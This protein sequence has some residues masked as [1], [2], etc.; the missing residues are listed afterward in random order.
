MKNILITGGFGFI[1]FN[2][3]R[4]LLKN[5]N[6]IN[7]YVIDNL[8]SNPLPVSYIINNQW[9]ND[10]RVN[11]FT[12]NIQ[13]AITNNKIPHCDEVYH[14]ASIVGPV[15]VIGHSGYIAREIVDDSYK[16][17]EF[18]QK[19][20]S[21]LLYISTSEVYGGGIDGYCE[22]N[23]SCIIPSGTSA[24]LEYSL[25]KLTVEVA[26]ANLCKKGSLNA[27]S[28]RLFNVAGPGQSACGGFVLPRFIGQAML[29]QPLT[30][31]GEGKQVRAF[32]HV[33]DIV[34]GLFCLMQKGGSGDV[35]NIGADI[36]KVTI[37][38]LANKVINSC[39][40]KAK[41]QFC[42][43]K[44]LFGKHFV[45]ASDKFPSREK[46]SELGWQPEYSLADIIKDTIAFMS[47]LEKDLFLK[48]INT[49]SILD[50]VH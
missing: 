14:L 34:S 10:S 5:N 15:G 19:Y 35:F 3:V 48:L 49:P 4:E 16:I 37:I 9:N 43:P 28:A 11:Y 38:D 50:K 2:L 32:T 18:C 47:G 20:S 6:D 45:E 40:S 21:R 42:D 25:A 39:N 44:T 29:N 36:N 13:N 1:G 22:E 8:S 12:D 33:L 46:I 24:R 23:M 30:V 17:I 27:V 31:Y 26:V 41:I 7:I